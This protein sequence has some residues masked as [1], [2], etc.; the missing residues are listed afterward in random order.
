MKP[1]TPIVLVRRVCLFF[2]Y[3]P[4][5]NEFTASLSFH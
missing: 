5:N 3:Y 1:T 4:D 2:L